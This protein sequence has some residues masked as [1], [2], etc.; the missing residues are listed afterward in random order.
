[1]IGRWMLA[2]L[3]VAG[4]VRL[5]A[6][7]PINP[8]V[9]ARVNGVEITNETLYRN[10]QELL[11][12][13]NVNI[14]TSRVPGRLEEM[15]RQA[16]D[17]LIEHEL[18]WQEAQKKGLVATDEEVDKAVGDLRA[19]FKDPA[20]FERKLMVEGY[21]QESYRAH[22]RRMVSARKYLDSVASALP[23]VT[24]AELETFYRENTSRFT[25]PEQVHVRH[26]QINPGASP[27]EDEIKAVREK[28]TAI[29]AEARAGADFAALADKHSQD[30]TAGP[31]GDLGLIQRG[32]MSRPFEDAAFALKPGDTS[33]IV[34]SPFGY[35]LI[36]VD[37]HLPS[38][39]LP[40]DEVRE[41]L[42][43]Y[44]REQSAAEAVT[45]ELERLRSAAN[46]EILTRF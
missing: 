12:E 23:P 10:Y 32:Q 41:K 28:L 5:A 21:T 20:A 25:F 17:S 45:Q 34:E 14:V 30:S 15:R 6:A 11:R 24:D 13:S 38:Q 36:R 2:A 42:R 26:I 33:D 22:M 35:H 40:L 4:T 16:L 39:L 9:A 37:E 19:A 31:G 43:E 8:G 46:V 27:S 18:A 44:L 7:Q 1:M 29:Q 3:V